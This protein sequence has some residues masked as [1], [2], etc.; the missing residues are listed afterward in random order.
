MQSSDR[1]DMSIQVT[2]GSSGE[3]PAWRRPV[4]TVLEIDEVTLSGGDGS[5]ECD[6]SHS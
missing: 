1:I 6:F 2:A 3:K 5:H 4:T